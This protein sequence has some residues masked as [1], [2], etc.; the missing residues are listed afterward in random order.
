MST[1]GFIKGAKIKLDGKEFTL[2]RQ[3]APGVWQLEATAT[4]ELR[5]V[6]QESMLDGFID[7]TMEFVLSDDGK[8]GAAAAFRKENA[9]RQFELLPE[10]LREQAKVR[11]AI[12]T[13]IIAE[14]GERW[15]VGQIAEK[16]RQLWIE[17]K[18]PLPAPHPTTV[19]RW[20]RRYLSSGKDIRSLVVCRHRCGNRT[21]RFPADLMEIVLNAVDKIYLTTERETYQTTLDHAISE[22]TRANRLR[23]ASDQLSLP[24]ITLVK[25]VVRAI[26]EF[27]RY[28]ARYG[29]PAAERRFRAVLG[30]NIV[31]APLEGVEIDHTRIDAFV[32]DDETYLPLG[33]PWFTIC[34]DKRTRFILGFSLSFDPP[35]HT[36]VARALK[37]AM[38]PKGDISKVYTTVENAWAAYGI[39]DGIVVDNGPEFHSESLEAACFSLGIDIQYCPRKQPWFKGAVER[40]QGTLNRGIAHGLPGTT[41]SNILDKADYDAAKKATVTL[42]TLREII[43]IWIIDYYHQRPHKGLGDTPAH[44]WKIETAGMDIRLP[45]NPREL[46]AVLGKI[47]SRR[48]TLKGIEI[49]NLF[50]NSREA[51]D[52]LRQQGTELDVTVR[53]SEDDLGHIHI[54]IPGANE[55]LLVPAVDLEYAK[56][57]T[58]WQHRVCKRFAAKELAGRTDVVALAEAKRR[59]RDLVEQ[60]FFRKGKRTRV[61]SQRFL[62]GGEDTVP[63]RDDAPSTPPSVAKAAPALGAP[64]ASSA[65]GQA[66]ATPAASSSPQ[67]RP[68]FT[69]I[70]VQRL[71]ALGDQNQPE[72]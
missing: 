28:A 31:N 23:P 44:A 12:V 22:V 20:T 2:T 39:M 33:R 13:A 54:L 18:Q 32:V 17:K 8:P 29:R 68:S 15:Q 60:D 62:A 6:T 30:K 47:A 19:W 70:Q 52:I 42:K 21:P 34:L 9:I 63:A 38:L 58:L 64:T 37:H 4:G 35:S 49:N 45:A 65:T 5:Q 24:T 27:D 14:F 71:P 56:G 46:D 7:G 10:A 59:I 72:A 50:Y 51:A 16:L 36:T 67:D 66:S 1:A 3:I 41:F 26:P 43:H 55:Y 57:L 53:Y 40:V 69:P 61:K 25:A 11:R 48:L